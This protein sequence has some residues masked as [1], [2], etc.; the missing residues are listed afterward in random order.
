MR[1]F[2]LL[3]RFQKRF[4][5]T[6]LGSKYGK[7]ASMPSAPSTPII[8]TCPDDEPEMIEKLIAQHGVDQVHVYTPDPYAKLWMH[9]RIVSE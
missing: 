3:P 8:F 1:K 2:A 7:H 9:D 5:C 6:S 4:I